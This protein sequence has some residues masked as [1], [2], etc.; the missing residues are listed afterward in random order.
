[1]A[2]TEKNAQQKHQ[3]GRTY[4]FNYPL[5]LYTHSFLMLQL[6]LQMTMA[7]ETDMLKLADFSKANQPPV[8]Y[9]EVNI[10]SIL[11]DVLNRNGRSKS[12]IY[13]MRE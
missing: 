13:C 3:T 4:V 7:T 9:Q 8:V 6:Q 11:Y 1:M 10:G 12:V 2:K 5:N